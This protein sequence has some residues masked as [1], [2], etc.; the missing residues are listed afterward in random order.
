MN[1]FLAAMLR[2]G[3]TTIGGAFVAKGYVDAGTWEAI[4]GGIL[5]LAGVAWSLAHKMK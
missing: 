2:H 3:L 5:A 4:A 1:P